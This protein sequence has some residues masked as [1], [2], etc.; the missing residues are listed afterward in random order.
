MPREKFVAAGGGLQLIFGMG[1]ISGP[2][3]C[4]LFMEFFGLNGFFVFL[5]LIHVFIGFFGLYRMK[6]RETV[7]NP[8]SSFTPVPATITPAGLELDPDAPETLDNNI[9]EK[10]N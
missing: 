10:N 6:M 1:A 3:L 7:E 8:D 4:S 5:I 2:I 9:T